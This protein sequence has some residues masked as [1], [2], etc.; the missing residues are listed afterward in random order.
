MVRRVWLV[1]FASVCLIGP[2]LDAADLPQLTPAQGGLNAER[3][4]EIDGLVAMAISWRR[5]CR[6]A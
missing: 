4:A 3:L 1:L 2:H 6:A 5:G